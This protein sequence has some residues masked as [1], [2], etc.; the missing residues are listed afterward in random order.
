MMATN[1]FLALTSTVN[2]MFNNSDMSRIALYTNE[3]SPYIV[4]CKN[5]IRNR[6]YLPPQTYRPFMKAISNIYYT[7]LT[8]PDR[9]FFASPQDENNLAN[10]CQ[11]LTNIHKK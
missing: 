5:A 4:A 7:R 3:N 9:L 6:D 2:I 8:Y 1:R 11:L 10:T